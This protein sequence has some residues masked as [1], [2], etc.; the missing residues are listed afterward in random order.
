MIA[1]VA[2]TAC[3]GIAGFGLL[4]SLAP[5]LPATARLLISFPT[6]AAVYMAVSSLWVVMTNAVDPGPVLAVSGVIGVVGLVDAAVRGR[7]GW[8]REG[9][10][11]LGAIAAVTALMRVLHLTVL[12]PDSLRYLLFSIHIVGPEGLDAVHHPD[13]LKRQ[14]G[15]PSLHALSVLTDRR[16]LAS[17]GP[18]FGVS[19][20]G[21]LSWTLWRGLLGDRRRLLLVVVAG[22][23]LLSSNR[24][25][26]SWFYINTHIAIAAYLLTAVAGTWIAVKE[27]DN[28]W[29]WPV[30]IA[31]GAVIL[32]RPD[33]PLFAAAVLGA[34]AATPLGWKFRVPAVVPIV[35]IA[36]LWYGLTLFPHPHY[37]SSMSLT[38]P[39]A[40]NIA[41]IAG[42]VLL[43]LVAWVP[44]PRRLANHVDSLMLVAMLLGFAFLAWRDLEVVGDTAKATVMNVESGGWLF[45]WAALTAVTVVALFRHRIPHGRVWTVPVMAFG[46]LYWILPLLREGA[47]RVG[48]GDSGNRILI[49]FVAIVVGM[50]VLAAARAEDAPTRPSS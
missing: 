47:W 3:L 48:T 20:L 30:G 19:T 7:R 36:T 5:G 40:G 22:A 41:A 28:S 12:S 27:K 8:W 39:V 16:Y 32:L 50:V 34:I 18:L 11:L 44:G 21:F 13:L 26:Y 17:I 2:I 38:S 24:F 46:L 37:Q 9:L 6:G 49:H 45:T 23:F 4:V 15:Y 14:L 42:A 31:L 10:I 1:E 35:V 29:A 25:L 43:V 33:S